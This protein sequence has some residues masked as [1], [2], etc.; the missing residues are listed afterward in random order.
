[1]AAAGPGRGEGYDAGRIELRLYYC[2]GC[3]RQ[4]ETQM[5]QMDTLLASL[6][7]PGSIA[8]LSYADGSW[9]P[10]RR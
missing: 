6:L 3:G 7:G 2:P 9:S 5:A 10:A 1:V 4:L 8:F